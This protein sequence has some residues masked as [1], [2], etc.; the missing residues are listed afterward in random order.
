MDTY[1]DED[2]IALFE[3]LVEALRSTPK[4]QRTSFLYVRE[5]GVSGVYV[6]GNGIA[7]HFPEADLEAL[8]DEALIRFEG[9]S[10]TVPQRAF[11]NYEELR[12]SRQPADEVEQDIFRH[13]DELEFKRRFPEAH[14]RWSEA[15]TLLWQSDSDRELSTIGHKCRE[16]IQ[17]FVTQL[18]ATHGVTA[19]NPDKAMTRDR[20]S[21]VINHRRADLGERKSALLDTLFGYWTATGDLIQRQ[22]HAGQ[23]EGESLT[24]E[25][26]RRVVFQTAILMFEVDRTL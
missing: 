16:A 3:R 23:R 4:P 17:E 12:T 7:E 22:E 2:Q 19:A 10:F 20:F 21:A 13:L 1:L 25:D 5:M 9:G 24:W 8:R 18:I 15:A 26:G 14:A 6:Q 11:A